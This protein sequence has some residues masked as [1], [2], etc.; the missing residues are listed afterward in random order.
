MS[1]GHSPA[2]SITAPSESYLRII[3]RNVLG[4]ARLSDV[5]GIVVAGHA[6]GNDGG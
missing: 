6:H 2:H 3:G 4:F 5:D 1:I